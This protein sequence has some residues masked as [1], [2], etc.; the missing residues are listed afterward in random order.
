[1]T[2]N[3]LP[4][5]KADGMTALA[6]MAYAMAPAGSKLKKQMDADYAKAAKKAQQGPEV[7]L[8]RK[9]RATDK[10]IAQTLEWIAKCDGT[11]NH[12]EVDRWTP[13]VEQLRTYRA[14]LVAKL[15]ALG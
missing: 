3:Q 6:G 13:Y 1:M 7:A 12:S 15:E 8:K 5:N 10:R 2:T 14:G 9:I 4:A 11:P